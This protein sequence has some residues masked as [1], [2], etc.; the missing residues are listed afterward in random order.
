MGRFAFKRFLLVL[1][2][3]GMEWAFSKA[4][5]TSL[6]TWFLLNFFASVRG[7]RLPPPV[8]GFS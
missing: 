5:M 8:I 6:G 7:G 4:V 2:A 3:L 1:H